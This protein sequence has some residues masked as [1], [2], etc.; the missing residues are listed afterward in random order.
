MAMIYKGGIAPIV[1]VCGPGNLHHLTYQSA[2][3]GG[4]AVGMIPTTNEGITNFLLSFSQNYRA[5]AFYWD[6]EGPAFWRAGNS[7]VREAVG[8]S[9]A[10]ATSVPINEPFVEGVNVEAQAA[11]AGNVGQTVTVFFIPHDLD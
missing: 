11:A 10:N 5:Y 2:T 9:W 6:G 7:T 8:T 4:T 3:N 1:T